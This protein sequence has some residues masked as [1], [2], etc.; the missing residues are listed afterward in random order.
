[1]VDRETNTA[2]AEP[3]VCNLER[4]RFIEDI[5]DVIDGFVVCCVNPQRP[6]VLQQVPRH[7]QQLRPPLWSRSD[8]RA[9]IEEVLV[10]PS[11]PHKELS[12]AANDIGVHQVLG[13]V[14]ID[15][16]VLGPSLELG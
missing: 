10:I 1:M 5:E 6:S 3:A 7:V 16:P 12:A 14:C 8:V 9:I 2:K 4:M 11:G 13:P 15:L